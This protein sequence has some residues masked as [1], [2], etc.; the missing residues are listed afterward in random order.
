MDWDSIIEAYPESKE[1]ILKA[2]GIREKAGEILEG[3]SIPKIDISRDKDA[4]A[5]ILDKDMIPVDTMA[6]ICKEL[7][8]DMFG[9]FPKWDIADAIK[10][11]ISQRH[12]PEVKG[13]N[14]I[15][16]Y[17]VINAVVKGYMDIFRQH[18]KDLVPKE[19]REGMCPFCSSYPKTAF[20]SETGRTLSCA[21]CGYSWSFPRIKCPFCN[22]TDHTSLGYFE[23]DGIDGVRVYY[24][25]ICNHYIKVTDLRVTDAKDPETQDILTLEMDEL[26][27]KEGFNPTS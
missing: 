23:A 27:I 5:G 21:I 1:D 18:N 11:F 25:R 17:M 3:L 15:I 9:V 10:K 16:V 19:W 13:Q 4:D 6:G 14:D 8:E 7:W 22:N 2:K 26:A 20:D 12:V 24:C